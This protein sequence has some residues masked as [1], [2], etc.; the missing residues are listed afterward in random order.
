M[1]KNASLG[2]VGRSA[3]YYTLG[4][5]I[6]RAAS[7][8]LLPVYTRYLSTADY[9][10]MEL[11]G[12]VVDVAAILFVSGMNAGMQRFYFKE[13]AGPG[14]DGVVSTTFWLE[15]VLG[16]IAAL[17]VIL[18]APLGHLIG[19]TQ[20]EHV[21]YLRVSAST[22]FFGV[23][24]SVPLLLLQSLNR[25]R[26]Y[27]VVSVCKL[28]AQI[29]LNLL[30]LVYM[31]LGVAGMLYTGL[32]V[33]LILGIS[34]AIWMARSVGLRLHWRDVTRLRAFGVPYQISIA[35][36][37]LLVFGDRFVLGSTKPVSE[38]GLYGLAYQ[39]GFLL[40]SLTEVP[41]IRAWNP[42]RYAMLDVDPPERDRAYNEGLQVLSVLLALLASGMI[43]FSPFVLS[44]MTSP[45]FHSAAKFV[46]V[47]VGAYVLQCYTQVVVFGI[48]VSTKTT[49]YT[50]ATWTSAIVSVIL[51]LLLI[52][53]FGGMGAAWATLLAFLVRF[54][55]T[56]RSAQLVWPIAYR[57]GPT[58]RAVSVIVLAAITQAVIQ[59][60]TAI[61]QLAL[62]ILVFA[63]SACGLWF[64][65]MSSTERTRAWRFLERALLNRLPWRPVRAA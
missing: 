3:F 51:Y 6:S 30:F 40:S 50:F 20:P 62:G 28:V 38:V 53:R 18:A 29:A 1:N 48:D 25:A 56:Y 24:A 33:N 63:A 10:V 13:P 35:G 31:G 19:L 11:L 5:V 22:F 49:H 44:V 4:S 17:V 52:P 21:F 32:I 64:V 58:L 57:W 15:I 14:R 2:T 65:A 36:S 12:I 55:M 37:F 27:L 61:G 54:G 16:F 47:I 43:L 42:V 8:L 46:P 23:L 9:G 7:L 41:F 26:V 45:E 34:L 39:F 59:P 60:T